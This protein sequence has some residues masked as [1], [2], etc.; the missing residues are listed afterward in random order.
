MGY[1]CA[2]FKKLTNDELID[3]KAYIIQRDGMFKRVTKKYSNVY[4]S[5]FR[6]YFSALEE[7]PV[8]DYQMKFIRTENGEETGDVIDFPADEFDF[9]FDLDDETGINTMYDVRSKMEDAWYDLQGRKI[10]NSQKPKAKG[11][12]IRNGKKIIIK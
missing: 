9:D 8:P 7:L 4:V 11:L 12:Y 1:W 2:T 10:A 3:G 6:A 5:P